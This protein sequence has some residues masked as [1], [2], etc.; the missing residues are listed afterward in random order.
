MER[1]ALFHSSGSA[2]LG[3]LFRGA[4]EECTITRRVWG[5]RAAQVRDFSALVLAV[6]LCATAAAYFLTRS[7][8]DTFEVSIRY[9]LG[10]VSQESTM[11]YKE[12]DG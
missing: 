1:R 9:H 12:I 4:L 2:P 10:L 5:P 6:T 3:G 11:L 8:L 7:S